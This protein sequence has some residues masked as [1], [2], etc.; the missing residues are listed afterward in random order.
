MF[1]KL[2]VGDFSK[3][4]DGKHFF[5]LEESM[6]RNI[7]VWE[8]GDAFW[9]EDGIIDEVGNI[10]LYGEVYDVL[11]E[12]YF[13][14]FIPGVGRLEGNILIIDDLFVEDI[15]FLDGDNNAEIH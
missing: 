10:T 15:E 1:G 9:V 12:K 13:P 4:M 5:V 11:L 3:V 6:N 2:K 14:A 8:D 7:Y